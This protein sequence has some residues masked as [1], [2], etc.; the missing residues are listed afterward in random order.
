M[1][2]GPSPELLRSIFSGIS[3]QTR[4]GRRYA[5]LGMDDTGRWRVARAADPDKTLPGDE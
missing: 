2:T 4:G 1:A 3:R 5:R